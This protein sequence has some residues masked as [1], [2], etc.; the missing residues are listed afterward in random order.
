MSDVVLVTISDGVADVRLNRPEVINAF[1]D[2][3]FE[4]LIEVGQALRADAGLRSV[5]L[6]GGGRGFCAGMDKSRF[7]AQ[8]SGGP[9]LRA[10]SDGDP[11]RWGDLGGE[12]L[13]LARGQKAVWIWQL[14]EVPV[15]AAIHGAAVGRDCSWP[16]APICA[17]RRV[18][19]NSRSVRS[20][21]A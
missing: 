11:N 14:I 3:L 15:I 16:W 6:S 20:I 5:V 19:R 1:N 12:G 17:M 13:L 21:G 2:E 10:N 7:A 4:V 8:T 18:L 9:L